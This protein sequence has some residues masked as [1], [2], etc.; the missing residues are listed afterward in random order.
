MG[1]DSLPKYVDNNCKINKYE[2]VDKITLRIPIKYINL[3]VEASRKYR[4]TKSYITCLKYCEKYFH[5]V[6]HD[7]IF[8]YEYRLLDCIKNTIDE[9]MKQDEPLFK[10]DLDWEEFVKDVTVFEF[11]YAFDFPAN[12]YLFHT[13]PFHGPF[14]YVLFHK[15]GMTIYSK[16]RK[17]KDDSEKSTYIYDRNPENHEKYKS[18]AKIYDRT[19]KLRYFGFKCDEHLY[20]FEYLLRKREFKEMSLGDLNYNLTE[21]K[22][23]I[24][25]M[26]VKYSRK[27]LKSKYFHIIDS[28][29]FKALHPYLYKIMVESGC[30]A[31]RV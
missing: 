21:F 19:K 8:D 30:G 22:K 24:K 29:S 12:M 4:D 31:S 15:L 28:G 18:F 9:N 20:R 25:P 10:S 6:F 5:V 14:R 16:D 26:L 27:Y 7:D 2:S 13:V 1:K 17:L 23:K 3:I 11:E